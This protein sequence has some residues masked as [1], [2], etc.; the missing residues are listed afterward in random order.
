MILVLSFMVK[1]GLAFAQ[2]RSQPLKSAPEPCAWDENL[3]DLWLSPDHTS[4]RRPDPSLAVAASAEAV[5]AISTIGD[6][7]RARKS[8]APA[9]PRT[10]WSSSCSMTRVCG[11]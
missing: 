4:M 7:S 1:L 11:R 10:R 9:L 5:Q 2:Y 3:L 8:Q 6:V